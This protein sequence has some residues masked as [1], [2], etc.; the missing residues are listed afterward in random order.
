M[1][2]SA[3]VLASLTDIADTFAAF[4]IATTISVLGTCTV[5]LVAGLVVGGL[6]DR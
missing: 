6:M 2:P 4:R 1:R 5:T 3:I